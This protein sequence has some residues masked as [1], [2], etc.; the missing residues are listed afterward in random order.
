MFVVKSYINNWNESTKEFVKSILDEKRF[1]VVARTRVNQKLVVDDLIARLMAK[2]QEQT[3]DTE[4]IVGVEVDWVL[5]D[6]LENQ[7]HDKNGKWIHSLKHGQWCIILKKVKTN[8]CQYAK[9]GV[10]TYQPISFSVTSLHPYQ[11][12]VTYRDMKAGSDWFG[13]A[14]MQIALANSFYHGSIHHQRAM[15]IM[16]NSSF[17]KPIIHKR[18]GQKNK[19]EQVKCLLR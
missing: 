7:L 8:M 17:Q 10:T 6:D 14:K 2:D 19:F 16:T 12:M 5:S 11:V 1:H 3:Y 18:V 15:E 13:F 9:G 4:Q